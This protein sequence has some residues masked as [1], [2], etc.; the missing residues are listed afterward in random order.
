MQHLVK[1]NSNFVVYTQYFGVWKQKLWCCMEFV[2]FWNSNLFVVMLYGSCKSREIHWARYLQHCG[3]ILNGTSRKVKIPRKEDLNQQPEREVHPNS[4]M[5][6]VQRPC[7]PRSTYYSKSW[8]SWRAAGAERSLLLDCFLYSVLLRWSFLIV[9]SIEGRWGFEIL[10][11]VAGLCVCQGCSRTKQHDQLTKATRGQKTRGPGDQGTRQPG[12]RRPRDQGTKRTRRPG[13]QENQETKSP[14]DQGTKRTRGPIEPEDK[15]PRGPGTAEPLIFFSPQLCVGFC[16]WFLLP[17]PACHTPS[18]SHTIFVTYHLSH[19]T[20]SRTIFRH[21]IFHTP[22]LSH[23]IFHTQLCHAPSF[24]TPS[25]THHLSHTIIVTY[26]HSH[27]TLS[28]TIFV[29]YHLS[30]T[31]LSRTIF[32]THLCHIPSFTYNFLTHHLSHTI[33]HI[34]SLSHTTIHR[35]LCHTPSLSH[36]IFHTQLCHAPSFDTP[37]FTHHLSHT[38]CHIPS[39][40]HTIFH[41]QLCRTPSLSHTIFH[42]QCHAPSYTLR[43]RRGTIS[44]PLWFH[45]AGVAQSHIHLRFAWQAWHNLTSTLVLRG[46][47][48]THGT[49]WRAWAGFGRPW[50]RGTLRGRRGTISHP[51]WFHVAGVAQS[52]IHLRFAWQAW[53]SW[54]WVARLGWFW[55]PVTPR[56]FAWQRGTISH[57]LWFR[58]AGLTQSHIHFCFAW[59]A[60]HNLTST[61]VLR[62]RRGTYGTGWRAWAGFVRPWRRGTLR[63]RRGTISHPLWFHVAGV[64]QSRIHFRFVWQAWRNLTS[65]F[66]LRGRRGT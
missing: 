24:D 16:F 65:T 63:G 34:P 62:G 57:P 27:T 4:F 53:R 14:S 10:L 15:G 18:L 36:T 20:L 32:H 44:H 42:T 38:I 56:H 33:C 5:Y 61:F 45:V 35:Q 39:L 1:R 66:V 59:Q 49:G 17:P 6:C 13:D 37:S 2:A 26:H 12:T 29:T 47:R 46:R 55:S 19:T 25:F 50:R 23:T 28:H 58:V 41:T 40:S 11:V 21:T 30:H 9:T 54:H 22:S 64:A 52:H 51:L 31:T 7:L 48:G 8:K 3:F 60:W 43:G